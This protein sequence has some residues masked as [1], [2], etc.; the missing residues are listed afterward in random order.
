MIR[1]LYLLMRFLLFSICFFVSV[2]VPARQNMDSMV[3]AWNKSED[4]ASRASMANEISRALTFRNVDSA[5]QFAQLAIAD[6]SILEDKEPLARGYYNLG[7]SFHVQGHFDSAEVNY[8][9]S[10]EL[11]DAIEDKS[12]LAGLSNNLGA[13]Y[14]QK[15]V[16]AQALI[17]YLESLDLKL[18]SG[19]YRGAATTLNNIGI[20][21]FDQEQYKEALEYYKQAIKLDE[22]EDNKVG[23][24]RSIGN[25]GL[26][27]LEMKVYDSALAYYQRAYT[28]INT[29]DVNCLKMYATNGLGQT[30]FARYQLTEAEK[31]A[32]LALKEAQGCTDPVIQSSASTLLGRIALARRNDPEA[33]RLLLSGHRIAEENDLKQE[34]EEVKEVL[35]S[36]YKNRGQTQ[37]SLLYLESLMN[38]K[39][40]LFNEGLTKKLIT[41]E[42]N[43][44]F[45]QEKDSIN[46][47]MERE[48]VDLEA[49]IKRRNLLIGASLIALGLALAIVYISLR[50]SRLKQHANQLLS[51]KNK[52]VTDALAQKEEL[53]KE[54][55]HRVKNNLQIVSSLLSVQARLL[56]D[57]KAVSAMR[58]TKSRVISMALVHQHLY[59]QKS[60]RHVNVETY[61]ASL[62]DSINQSF[63][64][65]LRPINI[66]MN[67]D[68]FMLDSDRAINLGFIFN[69][70]ITNAY[71]HAF[72]TSYRGKPRI[73][74][75][76]KKRQAD[77]QLLISDN[78]VGLKEEL[79]SRSYGM[80]LIESITSRMDGQLKY[81]NGL[82]TTISLSFP[83]DHVTD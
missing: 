70:L 10:L 18:E 29:E 19:N 42:L 55:H 52:V 61:L 49:K 69:E 77:I 3:M 81:T 66:V 43:H 44:A 38:L 32:K 80:N 54:M 60:D 47:R 7:L 76:L 62:I 20:I 37:K 11:K 72:P 28:I 17:Y 57:E 26:T 25:V 14:G 58:E 8:R 2:L 75:K 56:Q 9:K 39:D 21:K 5:R 83:F 78:G 79:A 35:Y 63:G 40:S 12:L 74:I 34:L 48:K 27:F 16:F 82:G 41:L 71:K 36:F 64:S 22:Q 1:T 45:E 30:Y 23:L 67:I 59:Q 68:P 4:K 6:A 53:F 46:F 33:E 24:S 51:E 50:A 73:D 15:G 65:N 13:I 31:Y